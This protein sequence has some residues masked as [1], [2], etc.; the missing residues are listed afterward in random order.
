LEVASSNLKFKKILFN[1]VRGFDSQK[2]KIEFN[3]VDL[4]LKLR[5]ENK[6]NIWLPQVELFH[7]ESKTRE[8]T[9]SNYKHDY[10]NIIRR[11]EEIQK[12]KTCTNSK[13]QI[14]SQSL[15]QLANA[16]QK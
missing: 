13:F 1:K 5:E 4:C 6:I 12:I 10:L 7:H 2:F 11:I 3:D 15:S 14:T 16:P 8:Y 9:K